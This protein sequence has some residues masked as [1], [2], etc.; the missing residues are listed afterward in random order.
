MSARMRGARPKTHACLSTGTGRRGSEKKVYGLYLMT[1]M[2]I[3]H[4]SNDTSTE[5]LLG[6]PVPTH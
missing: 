2:N 4:Y 3:Q 1:F 6:L 5:N